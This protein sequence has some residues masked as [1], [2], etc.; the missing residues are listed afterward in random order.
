MCP[1]IYMELKER[2]EATLLLN[3]TSAYRTTS[4][5]PDILHDSFVLVNI[6]IFVVSQYV[7]M[8]HINTADYSDALIF[9]STGLTSTNNLPVSRQHTYTQLH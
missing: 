2:E 4:L 5:Q 6:H 1:N 3:R 8:S 7:E 9:S